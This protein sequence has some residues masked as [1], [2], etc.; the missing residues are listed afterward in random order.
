MRHRSWIWFFASLLLLA[1]V[2][3]ATPWIVNVRQ[4]LTLEEL[5]VK[6]SLW[7]EHGPRDYHLEYVE[8]VDRD[9]QGD[10][11]QVEVRGGKVTAAWCNGQPATAPVW[12]VDAM[13]DYIESMLEEDRSTGQ[14]NYNVATFDAADGHPVHYVRWVRGSQHRLEWHVRLERET[15]GEQ[16]HKAR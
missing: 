6:E 3:V 11:C 4:Q 5:A 9:P 10:R 8:L 16:Q 2:A 12:T 13:Y 7:R 15:A 14:R 1:A